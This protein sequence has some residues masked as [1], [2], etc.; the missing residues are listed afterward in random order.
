MKLTKSEAVQEHRKMWNWIADETEK[1]KVIVA[2]YDYFLENG[3]PP[4][5][6]PMNH[7]WCCEYT[8][9]KFCD[10]CPIVWAESCGEVV[11]NCVG[12]KSPY[13]AW[14]RTNN[15]QEAS[16]LARQIANLPEQT[17]MEFDILEDTK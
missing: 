5:E 10:R 4:N 11:I 3:I 6:H 1:R 15:W 12:P 13:R 14:M 7:C 16:E 8:E 9:Y 2:K 17:D